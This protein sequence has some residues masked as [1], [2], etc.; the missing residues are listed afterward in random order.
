MESGSSSLAEMLSN[1]DSLEVIP[2]LQV[3]QFTQ[4]SSKEVGVVTRPRT[5]SSSS[6]RQHST[7][8]IAV[9]TTE[10]QATSEEDVAKKSKVGRPRTKPPKEKT[11]WHYHLGG[12]RHARTPLT[13][14]I[15]EV[16]EVAYVSKIMA[17]NFRKEGQPEKE[18][19]AR[20]T[21]LSMYKIHE[22]FK[23]R[24]KKDKLLNERRK[25]ERAAVKQSE[26]DTEYPITIEAVERTEEWFKNRLKSKRDRSKEVTSNKDTSD[27][28]FEYPLTVNPGFLEIQTSGLVVPTT[29]QSLPNNS[30]T[31][32]I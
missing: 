25:S 19:I 28:N 4:L 2:K 18:R 16:L 17:K 6:S 24:R 3:E 26:G 29:N 14:E 30:G 8:T 15:R 22:W 7:V 12:V 31:V 23:N 5:S 9:A 21:G 13:P 20:I 1:I 27:G 11:G 10:S 32:C